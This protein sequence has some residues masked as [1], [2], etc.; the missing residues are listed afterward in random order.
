M[1]DQ[2][3]DT[4]YLEHL[5]VLRKSIIKFLVFLGITFVVAA[6]FSKDIFNFISD[7]LISVL[8][9]GSS[10][11][12]TEVASPFLTPLKFAFYLALF[13]S[14]PF[15]I[16]QLIKFASPGLYFEEKIYFF[17]LVLGSILLFYL[18]ITFAYFI[19]L[20]IVFSFFS[21]STP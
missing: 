12:A 4:N 18:G 5:S 21:A 20:P 19:I 15:L 14:I 8:P 9:T 17:P 16:Y 3:K 10:L 2:D 7:P 13:V 11:I 6:F 1:I